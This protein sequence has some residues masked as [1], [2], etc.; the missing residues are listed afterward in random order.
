MCLN[1][2]RLA[3]EGVSYRCDVWWID[4]VESRRSH[5]QLC[6]RHK[7]TSPSWTKRYWFESQIIWRY[8]KND[9]SLFDS[10]IDKLP[11]RKALA[12]STSAIATTTVSPS[13]G[14]AA[15]LSNA[16]NMPDVVSWLQNVRKSRRGP[17]LLFCTLSSSLGG[18][19]NI[20]SLLVISFSRRM[21]IPIFFGFLED[22]QVV[23]VKVVSDIIGNATN[24]SQAGNSSKTP[25]ALD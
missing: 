12:T 1:W 7:H 9:D 19:P 18:L 4:P 14:K 25:E 6:F 11:D 22:Y 2:A 5:T 15:N 10:W 13:E 20:R 8:L 16:S 24:K 23:Q 3:W 17:A 21:Y